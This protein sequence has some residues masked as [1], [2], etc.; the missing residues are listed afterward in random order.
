MIFASAEVALRR[1]RVVPWIS[2]RPLLAFAGAALLL[3]AVLP[4]AYHWDV[5]QDNL[6]QLTWALTPDWGYTKHPPFPTWVLIAFQQVLPNGLWLTFAL[7]A[8]QVALMMAVAFTLTAELYG[9]RAAV[10]AVL[11]IGLLTY[12]TQRLHF[13][14][15]NTALLVAHA[16]ACLCVW[17]ALVRGGTLWWWLLG[18]VW[19]AGLLSKYQMVLTIA[20]NLAYLVLATR[21]SPWRE[22]RRDLV[23]GVLLAGT[24][25]ALAILPHV[26]WLVRNDFPTFGYASHSMA[27]DL[28]LAARP[29]DIAAFLGN[30]VGRCLPALLLGALLLLLERRPRS[31]V[32]SAQL[33]ARAL[34]QGLSPAAGT[35][36]ARWLLPV[37]ALGPFILMTALSAFLGVDLQMH[38]GTAFLWLM[39]PLAL[40]TRA[41][42]RLTQVP[43]MQVYAGALLVHLLQLAAHSL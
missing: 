29:R 5:P 42:R 17:R 37:H 26:I 8:A 35:A 28:P 25:A 21:G 24:V 16:L 33:A 18:L 10:V 9:R 34:P 7:G 13:Y 30:Q 32:P 3:W 40:G 6:E 38:W 1:S 41:G 36:A 43:L 11:L 20:C 15:H 27:A 19:G 2:A 14:N 31:A 22:E 12:Y 39:V 23:R 4:L